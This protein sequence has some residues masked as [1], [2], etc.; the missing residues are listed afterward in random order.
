MGKLVK[1][2]TAPTFVALYLTLLL[3]SHL[4]RWIW[5]TEA[6]PRPDQKSQEVYEVQ[7]TQ[8]T[9]RSVEIAYRDI[10]PLTV[11]DAPVLILVHGSPIASRSFD[12]LIEELGGAYRLIVP[13]LPGFGGS[14][15][16]IMDYSARAHSH[17]LLQLMDKLGVTRAHLLGYSMGG[18]V[19]LYLAQAAPGRVQ[20]LTFISSIGVQELELL[21]DYT[22]NHA[23]HSLQLVGLWM[24]EECFPHFGWMDDALLNVAYARNFYDTDQRPFRKI[25]QHYDGPLCIVHGED[26]LLVPL[27]VAEENYRMVPQSELLQFSGGHGLIFSPPSAMITAI[28]AFI[29]KVERGDGENRE[30]ANAHRIAR[31]LEPFNL[32]QL[33][34]PQGY[35][36]I[37]LMTLL[38]LATLVSE[39]LT[40]ISAG[41]LV[42]RNAIN[43][44]PAATACLIGIFVGDI[45]LYIAGRYIGRAALNHAPLRWFLSE[46]AVSAS[47]RWFDRK[48]P[49]LIFI[50]R[51]IPGTRLPTYFAA[52]VVGQRFSKFL[53][54]FFLA[55]LVWTP[56]LVFISQTIG[57]S[58][59]SYFESYE[60]Y[61][62]L[63]FLLA[64]LCLY[65]ISRILIPLFSHRGR[66]LLL[67][68]WRRL[69]R[70]EF[71]P[72][73]IFYFPVIIYILYLCLKHR[74]LTLFTAVNPAIPAGGFVNESKSEILKNLKAKT[75]QVARFK[76]I[77][78]NLSLE[79]KIEH[80]R[81]FSHESN[82]PHFPVVLKPD[83]GERGKGVEIIENE[84]QAKCYFEIHLEDT[85]IQEFV[86]GNEFGIFYYRFPDSN[87][88]RIFSITEKRFPAIV[89]DGVQTLESLI[90]NDERAVCKAPFFLKKF[91]NRLM[92]IPDKGETIALTDVGT[93]CLGALFLDGMHIYSEQLLSAVDGMSKQY[94]G[95]YFGRY[96]II[97]SS[98]DSI[99]QGGDFKV[100]ELNGLTSE[101]THIYDPRNKLYYAYRTLMKQWR[102]AFKIAS[103]NQKRGIN[104]VSVSEMLKLIWNYWSGNK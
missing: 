13:D 79:N 40:C 61:A 72:L 24:I 98:V 49:A 78:G 74:S 93:H 51:F 63:S 60:R 4:T 50:T 80:L 42:A 41:L 32:T 25:L 54:Y 44:I 95:F 38:A 22:L 68:S 96:D 21:G 9:D 31:S 90:L 73:W 16:D 35:I 64:A 12:T 46:D 75:E 17:Y 56:L 52:G 104:P 43:F 94:D 37:F 3:L 85:I 10:N 14:T 99:K 28:T 23:L 55:A 97:T 88:G 5:P 69:I 102:I 67:S 27:S 11:E 26:D 87:K 84:N 65:A 8:S 86:T 1:L 53:I 100:I 20:S 76:T 6:N 59:L 57:G 34:K 89:G 18:G 30:N 47:Q 101:A 81:S 33:Q 71:W 29:N 103:M 39:D 92:E 66:R 45:L 82:G 15:L 77:S 48:G 91:R 62:L 36:L 2:L 70:W 7:G 83:V 58:I 19:N